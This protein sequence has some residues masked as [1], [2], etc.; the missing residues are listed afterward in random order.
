MISL[1]KDEIKEILFEGYKKGLTD[2]RKF[3]W[4]LY[5]ESKKV[6]IYLLNNRFIVNTETVQQLCN[7]IDDLFESYLESKQKI[8]DIIG[9]NCFNEKDIGEF[10]F[11]KFLKISGYIK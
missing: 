11:Y 5:I 4:Y 10:L 2:E 3:I 6:G 1:D 8:Y 9:A 7:I